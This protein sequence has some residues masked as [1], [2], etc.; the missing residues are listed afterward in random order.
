MPRFGA[1]FR[2]SGGR[3]VRRATRRDRRCR[4]ADTPGGGRR[5]FETENYYKLTLDRHEPE[6]KV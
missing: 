5:G 6:D 4:I 3:L 2:S 1:D